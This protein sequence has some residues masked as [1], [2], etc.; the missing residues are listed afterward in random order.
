M[1]QGIA[2]EVGYGIA[3]Y[4]NSSGWLV[5]EAQYDENYEYDEDY[6]VPWMQCV[7]ENNGDSL[8]QFLLRYLMYNL[9]EDPPGDEIEDWSEDKL[10]D[11]LCART[12]LRVVTY[13]YEWSRIAVVALK[14]KT[15]Y[16]Y[17][18][19]VLDLKELTVTH[20]DKR[21]MAWLIETLRATVTDKPDLKILV[22]FG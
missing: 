19:G 22:S 8:R 1:S 12:G 17:D 9:P 14:S 5:A 6:V 21:W 3:L 13:G 10:N 18:P 2:T 7:D 11:F 20:E 16:G 4:D 15:F